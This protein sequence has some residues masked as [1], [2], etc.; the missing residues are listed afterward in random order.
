MCFMNTMHIQADKTTRPTTNAHF[1]NTLC[2]V[3]I[4]IQVTKLKKYAKGGKKLIKQIK[5]YRATA[6]HTI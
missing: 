5:K 1:Y 6:I 3:S 4:D 2:S